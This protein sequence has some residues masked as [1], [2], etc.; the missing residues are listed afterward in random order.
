M[1]AIVTGAAG[2]VGYHV[3]QALLARGDTVVGIDNLNP[4]YDVELKRARLGRL[5]GQA[6]F[7]F[8]GC[9]I[10]D[11][12]AMAGLFKRERRA[13]HVVHLAAQAGVRHSMVDPYSY[14]TSNVMG[15]VAVLEAARHLDRL[16]HIVY[17]SSSSVYGSNTSLPYAESDPV[18]TPMSLYAATKRADEL[19]SHAYGHLYGLPQTGLRF[20]TVYGPWGRPDMAYFVFAEAICRGTPITLYDDGTLKR[21][22]TYI[23]DIVG[24]VLACLGRP[25]LPQ[26][27]PLVFNIGNNRAEPVAELVRLLEVGLGRRAVTRS[28]SRPPVDVPETCADLSA[29]ERHVGYRPLT[30]LTVGVPRFVEWFQAYRAGV[31]EGA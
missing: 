8:E 6:G 31:L 16:D 15:H 24:G 2:F 20:F 18:D 23:D 19:I 26:E 14:V 7:R 27:G 28:A 17:A 30:P 3:C 29:I 9:D 13:T 1:H 4:Y 25:P 22:F 12:G 11:A 21:D 10:A 5:T